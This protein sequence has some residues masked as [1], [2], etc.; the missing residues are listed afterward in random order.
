[1]PVVLGVQHLTRWRAGRY[2]SAGLASLRLSPPG[3]TLAAIAGSLAQRK[4]PHR[5]FNR[6]VDCSRTS[7][8]SNVAVEQAYLEYVALTL[9]EN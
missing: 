8:V 9:G 2:Q 3:A 7:M 1:M 4:L 6:I 5:D